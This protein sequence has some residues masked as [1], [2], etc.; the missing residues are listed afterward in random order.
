ME[1]LEVRKREY[2]KNLAIKKGMK[3]GNNFQTCYKDKTVKRRGVWPDALHLSMEASTEVAQPGK[4]V[5]PKARWWW[6]AAV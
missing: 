2:H 4:M 6:A 1:L 3:K 5:T